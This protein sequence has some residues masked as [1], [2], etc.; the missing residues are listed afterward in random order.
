MRDPGSLPFL[1]RSVDEQTKAILASYPNLKGEALATASITLPQKMK[2]GYVKAAAIGAIQQS[3]DPEATAQAYSAKYP[4]YIK[5][6]EVQTLAKVAASELRAARADAR[7]EAQQ[8][9]EA[10]QEQRDAAMDKHITAAFDDPK[11]FN[12]REAMHDPAL[13][14]DWRGKENLHALVERENKPE[15]E[16]K[17]SRTTFAD[18]GTK[19]IQDPKSVTIDDLMKARTKEPG[20]AGGLTNA[21]FNELRNWIFDPQMGDT[22]LSRLRGEAVKGVMPLIDHSNPMM[23]HLDQTGHLNYAKFLYAVHQAEEEY[24]NTP[25]K[26]PAD[27]FNPNKP[28]YIGNPKF[29]APFLT[30]MDQ[31]IN[32]FA[33]GLTGA[34]QYGPG[35]K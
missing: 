30:S 9:K 3:S 8:Q 32:S 1:L 4:D 33:T 26:N 18:L 5:G 10:R 28:D 25:G 27:L 15:T 14:G 11:N 34:P 29:Y 31:S 13:A 20:E 24:R 23:G 17:V 35:G 2:E 19:I 22:K 16:A 21:D 6:A 7:W 12:L